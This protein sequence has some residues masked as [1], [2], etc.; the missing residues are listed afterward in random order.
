MLSCGFHK[1]K[2]V[3]HPLNECGDCPLSGTQSCP[4]GKF[5]KELPCTEEIGP[6]G[7]TCGKT[8]TCGVHVCAARCHR[9]NCGSCLQLILKKCRC[10]AKEKEVPCQKEFLCESK[11]KRIRDCKR[12][13]CNR[14]VCCSGAC[15]SCE[16]PCGRMLGCKNHKCN[17]R[18]HQGP[19]FP[20]NIMVEIKCFCGKESR[21]VPC[22]RERTS[23]PPRCSEPCKLPSDC[24]HPKRQAHK[25]HFGPCPPCNL[26]CEN[27]Y[28]NCPHICEARCHDFVARAKPLQRK[29]DTPWE[30]VT[31][32][33]V[34]IVKLPCP[35]CQVLVPVECFGK[36][37]IFQRPCSEAVPFSCQRQCGKHLSCTNHTCAL[38]CHVVEGAS[39][40]DLAGMNCETC[41]SPCEKPRPEGC[42]HP[43][44]LQ[45]K[46]TGCHPG[47]CPRCD[48]MVKLPCHCGINQ[49]YVKCYKWTAAGDEDKTKLL[50]CGNPCPK[51]MA[52]G[53]S[54]TLQCHQGEC[55]SDR[56]CKKKVNVKCACKR[57]KKEFPCVYIREQAA[58][59]A[60]LVACDQVCYDK[61]EEARKELEMKRKVEE[62]LRKKK[63]QEELDAFERKMKGG[64]KKRKHRVEESAEDEEQWWRTQRGLLVA[65]LAAACVGVGLASFFVF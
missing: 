63:E 38:E 23:K 52:C 45:I 6:C 56:T 47:P 36:H 32:P 25:C 22:G 41:Q 50:S 29:A 53:H 27:S 14:K 42:C 43:C 24:H 40:L 2:E 19:C 51:V 21:F 9:G 26:R 33:E 11:C 55:A 10:G 35:S 44:P 5:R 4:C 13:A 60:Q 57:K 59:L 12:H 8:L 16:Q 30:V 37:E 18:C 34:E 7:D 46:G 1:C 20:C 58:H 62:E 64:G 3:C 54:C 49:V 15:P 65:G 28:S 17:S 48:L 31:N 39:G 61:A